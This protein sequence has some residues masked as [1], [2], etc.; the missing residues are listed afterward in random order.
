M[1]SL[2]KVFTVLAT[3]CSL[4]LLGFAWRDIQNLNPPS[5][6]SFK[7]LIGVKDAS[8]AK[9]SNTKLYDLTYNRIINDYYRKVDRENL[10]YASL[11]GLTK[12]L[13]DPHTAFMVPKFAEAFELETKGNFV[14]VGARLAPD[15][16]GARVANVFDG[17]PAQKAGVKMND[18][19]TGVN[20]VTV[21]G[22]EVDAIV[23][24]IRGDEGTVVKLTIL[25]EK[26]SKPLVLAIRRAR[27]TT[28]TVEARLIPGT[29]IGYMSITNFAEPTIDQFDNALNGFDKSKIDGLIIDLRGNPGGLLQS[30]KDT[31][32]R[33]VDNKVIV[34]MRERNGIVEKVRTDAGLARRID[35]PIAILI[36][37]DSASAAEIFAGV[38]QDYKIAKLVGEHSYG[39]ASV[40]K[41]V[42]FI[43]RSMLKI[44]IARYYLPRGTDIG[45]RV[46]EDGTYISGGLQPDYPIELDIDKITTYG[47][48]KTDNQLQKAVE[49]VKNSQ[50]Q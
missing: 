44:T 7:R 6:A 3:S 17:S 25:R 45:R 42:Y 34:T 38:M 13:G 43:D 4:F 46:D 16:L 26:L 49:V 18:V 23:K 14:G 28:P 50:Y 36:N 31:L 9:V 37:E 15:P 47:D 33:F 29:N 21:S 41:P 27:I 39:K 8:A 22:K 48:I 12:S 19:I 11:E 40:Q 32:S 30:A 1:K 5:T 2:S 24:L 20:G 35:Y 10:K